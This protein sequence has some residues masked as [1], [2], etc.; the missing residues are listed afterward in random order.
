VSDELERLRQ[1]L[2]TL[3]QSQTRAV[4]TKQELIETRDRLDAELRR[5]KQLADF[6]RRALSVQGLSEFADLTAEAVVELFDLEFGAFVLHDTR[7]RVARVEGVCG[8]PR[9]RERPVPLDALDP[10]EEVEQVGAEHPLCVSLELHEAY[11]APVSGV[12]GVFRGA[13]LGGTRK[14]KASLTAPLASGARQ[15]FGVV[16]LQ[17]DSL[18]RNLVSGQI[19]RAKNQE[20]EASNKARTQF[21]ANVSHEI[22]TPL[23]SIINVPEGLLQAFESERRAGCANGHVFVLDA[24][25]TAE[26]CPSCGEPLREFSHRRFLGEHDELHDLLS[27]ATRNGR[28]LLAL[29]N[30]ILDASRLSAGRYDLTLEDVAV[31]EVLEATRAA[32][33]GVADHGDVAVRIDAGQNA[34]VHGDP[35]RLTQVL[36]NLVGN[37]IK[38]SPPGGTVDVSVSTVPGQVRIAVRDRGPGI[39]PEHQVDIFETFRQVPRSGHTEGK[40]GTG[41]GLSIAR[42]L[43]QAHGG[44]I[45]LD[46]TPGEGSTFT[47]VLPPLSNS[48]PEATP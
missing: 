8:P 47:L 48:E 42:Q 3:R 29:V 30:D 5:Y 43:A 33:A 10:I 35:A 4:S 45:E 2:A 40:Q 21:F 39:A 6:T 16:A 24:G 27:V 41:L 23:N 12:E 34:S 19:I 14:A 38:F 28:Y 11:V 37:A 32:C 44:A 1:E 7:E 15:S 18:F 17:V 46:S 26:T 31:S 13:V 36:T 22:R 20:L 25:E 9:Y